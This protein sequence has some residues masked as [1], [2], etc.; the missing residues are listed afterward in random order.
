MSELTDHQILAS[1]RVLVL[2]DGGDARRLPTYGLT[3]KLFVPF[4][5]GRD[6]LLPYTLFDAQWP[7]WMQLLE[8]VQQP[9]NGIRQGCVVVGCGDVLLTG[10][11]NES[12]PA[13]DLS[14]LGAT[15]IAVRVAAE[16]A[17]R[18]G[19]FV[20]GE[21]NRVTKFLQKPTVDVQRNLGAIDE[22]G[23]SLMDSGVVIF[24]PQ[25]ASLLIQA[26]DSPQSI[27]V[28]SRM[29]ATALQ[30]DIERNGCDLYREI[31]CAFG[32]ETT[33][34]DYSKSVRA[35]GNRWSDN[36]LKQF[37]DYLHPVSFRVIDQATIHF[38]HWGTTSQIIEN[39]SLQTSSQESGAENDTHH[40][41]RIL[42]CLQH[43]ASM[44]CVIA[45]SAIGSNERN[46]L[47]S[48]LKRREIWIEGCLLESLNLLVEGENLLVG[49]DIQSSLELPRGACVD[50][51]PLDLKH[52]GLDSQDRRWIVRWCKRD[53]QW[54]ATS[55]DK[56][57]FCGR[58]LLEWSQLVGAN[59]NDLWP[60]ELAET[61]KSIWNAR[62]FPV[63]NRPVEFIHWQWMLDP[64]RA[65][66]IDK[67]A[68]RE[69]VRY[70]QE[71]LVALADRHEILHRRL[72]L[73][74][75]R[76]SHDWQEA[77]DLGSELSAVDLALLFEF[78]DQPEQ[79]VH[80]LLAT[81]DHCEKDIKAEDEKSITH[82][83]NPFYASRILHSLGSAYNAILKQSEGDPQQD[84][85]LLKSL[86]LGIRGSRSVEIQASTKPCDLGYALQDSAFEIVRTTILGRSLEKAIAKSDSPLPRECELEASAPARLDLGGGWTDTPPYALEFGGA[87]TNLAVNLNER[88]PI[89]VTMKRIS[90]RAITLISRDR[91][92]Q[93]VVRTSAEMLSTKLAMS[94]F[95]IVKQ[96]LIQIVEN[97]A[98]KLPA[99]DSENLFESVTSLFE[100]G[101]EI[102]TLSE[103]P[104][105]SGL[106]TSSILG[107]VL[108]AVFHRA[109]GRPLS[110]ER[111]FD[112]TLRLEQAMTTGGGWQDQVGGIVGGVKRISSPPGLVPRFT[113]D[114]IPDQMFSSTA[115]SP[116]LLYYTGITRYAKNIL[117]RVVANVL[118]RDRR[119]MKVLHRLKEVAQELAEVLVKNDPEHMGSLID[120]AWRLNV[121]LVP[122]TTNE[123]VESLMNRVRP[124]TYGAKLLGAGGGGFMLAVCRTTEHAVQLKKSLM[125]RPINPAGKF[126][127]FQVNHTGL[128]I[129]VLK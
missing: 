23:Q 37:F 9:E 75:E 2:H 28:N 126:Y 1:L 22:N 104:Q 86:T 85:H 96:A 20:L 42:N 83:F 101:L 59:T 88:P 58:P 114:Q 95:S 62:I 18:H 3:G 61:D 100:G 70:S 117:R 13:L 98:H 106:G 47:L 26:L 46:N 103:M 11:S 71:D 81:I 12:Y 120:E 129:Q 68:W 118:D 110:I 63:I 94:E 92:T 124:F 14:D 72:R 33:F 113:I 17:S 44:N 119:T 125:E 89:R 52:R 84:S 24:S 54:G 102:S 64:S 111:L 109:L 41:Q 27:D 29:N 127:D 53:D 108:L 8:Y 34:A 4:P 51:I 115:S 49:V 45:E 76:L 39:G 67:K 87:V 38:Q 97:S 5:G 40:A 122:V 69:A 19:V 73:N 31:L 91:N 90:D 66:E 121:E 82:S 105:G 36:A 78:V 48:Q 116:C 55:V 57:V 79:T 80:R 56:A 99:S 32:E 15:G 74:A 93:E 50:A 77:F 6:R 10:F 65:S 128:D 123:E 25:T 16:I 7:F 21:R 35:A 112:E 107:G 30:K 60:D 43:M